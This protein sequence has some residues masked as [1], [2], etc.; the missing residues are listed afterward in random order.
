ML[1][2]IAW[3]VF[4]F[5]LTNI[6]RFIKAPFFLSAWAYSFPVAAFILATKKLVPEFS[7]PEYLSVLNLIDYTLSILIAKGKS[8]SQNRDTSLVRSFIYLRIRL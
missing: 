5:L 8:A 6:K 2:G 4:V 3:F 7:A 1:Y